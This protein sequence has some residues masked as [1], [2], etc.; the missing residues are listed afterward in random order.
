MAIAAIATLSILLGNLLAIAQSNLR[1]L[2]AYSAVAHA[3]YALIAVLAGTERGIASGVYYMFTYGLSI[4]GIFA[5]IGL[6]ERSQGDL[7]IRDL[8]GLSRRSPLLAMCLLV[9]VLSLAGIPPLAGFFGKFYVFAAALQADFGLLWIV[10]AAIGASAVSLY[11]YLQVLK[12]V[13]VVESEA[14][15]GPRLPFAPAATTA[16]LALA[17]IFLGCFPQ[18]LL[19]PLEQSVRPPAPAPAQQLTS[20]ADV[21]LSVK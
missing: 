7:N 16:V 21:S 17:V 14:A 10:A 19:G 18:V 9:F 5:V 13:F 1:R 20:A 4:V 15:P 2:L 8:A 6:L 3:G 12:Q 11:Y